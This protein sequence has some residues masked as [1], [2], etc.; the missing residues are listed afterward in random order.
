MIQIKVYKNGYE[1]IGHSNVKTCSEVS[2]L[3]WA[4]ANTIYHHFDESSKYYTSSVDNHPNPNEGYTWM[5]FD[6]SIEKAVLVFE[7]WKRNQNVW[8]RS[9]VEARRC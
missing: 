4:C 8:C 7:E 9:R 5:T 3:Q 6:T 2:I 1:I